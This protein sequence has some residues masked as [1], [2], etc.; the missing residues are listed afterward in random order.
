MAETERWVEVWKGNDPKETGHILESAGIE[1]R[2]A[3][4][5]HLSGSLGVFGWFRRPVLA[6]LLVRSDDKVR[7]HEILRGQTPKEHQ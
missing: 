7:A 5:S 2:I 6:R 3:T 1:M 4:S